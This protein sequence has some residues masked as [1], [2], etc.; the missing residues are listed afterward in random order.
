[1]G[2]LENRLCRSTPVVHIPASPKKAKKTSAAADP[3]LDVADFF[4]VCVKSCKIVPIGSSEESNFKKIEN[5][6]EYMMK[7]SLAC[8]FQ[9]Q[10]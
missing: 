9:I 10:S 5:R 8:K 6:D 7:A 1:M 3:A 2:R 4:T